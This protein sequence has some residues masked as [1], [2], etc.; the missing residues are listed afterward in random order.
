MSIGTAGLTIAMAIGSKPANALTFEFSQ[1]GWL[2]GG[3]EVT[4]TFTGEDKNGD[5]MI[6]FDPDP[7]FNEVSAYEMNFSGN[8]TFAD[9]THTLDNIDL[10]VFF[11]EYGL[12][13]SSIFIASIGD[14]LPDNTSNNNIVNGRISNYDTD[15]LDNM[16]I[17]TQDGQPNPI[18]TSEA[19]DVTPREVPEPTSWIGLILVGLSGYFQRKIN[20][21]RSSE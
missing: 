21:N 15:G 3:G 8:S 4:G 2:P 14:R 19:V 5:N 18:E 11:L 6:I 16:S 12:G 1:L 13:D 9:F 7:A 20:T 10:N 17:I